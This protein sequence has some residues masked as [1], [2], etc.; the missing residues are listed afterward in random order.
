MATAKPVQMRSGQPKRLIL[1]FLLGAAFLLVAL[2]V[3][4]WQPLNAHAV[5]GASQAARIGCACR[6]ISERELPS[7]KADLGPG[8]GLVFLSEDD[9]DK[10]VTALVPLLSSQTAKWQQGSGCVLEAW[11]D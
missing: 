2:L 9:E 6:Y 5:T 3:W 10:S 8:T 11:E 4:Y 7:C 1:R